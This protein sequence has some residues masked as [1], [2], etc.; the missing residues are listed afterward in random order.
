MKRTGFYYRAFLA[1]LL[2]SAGT[3]CAVELRV[4]VCYFDERACKRSFA[5]T[6]S[7]WNY[8]RFKSIAASH[9]PGAAVCLARPLTK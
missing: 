4:F 8:A 2:M 6:V 7:V 3:S 9:F 5:D 1:S